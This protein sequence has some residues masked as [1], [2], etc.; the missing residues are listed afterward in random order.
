MAYISNMIKWLQ[1]RIRRLEMVA[2]LSV[3]AL[4][5]TL[6]ALWL[7]AASGELIPR[8]VAA[9]RRHPRKALPGQASVE[10]VVLAGVLAIIIVAVL[11][12]FKDGLV[13]I[14]NNIIAFITS[15]TSG[16]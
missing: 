15:N 4:Q 3:Y 6:F 8:L 9:A 2:A 12:V 1:A 16:K 7:L 10:F 5:G 11:A 13:Q 14:T